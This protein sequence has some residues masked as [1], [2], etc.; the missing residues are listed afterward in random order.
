MS[1]RFTL[2]ASVAAVVSAFALGWWSRA[3]EIEDERAARARLGTE[4][5]RV[6]GEHTESRSPSREPG[7]ERVAPEAP[8][9]AAS[10]DA[11]SATTPEPAVVV[12]ASLSPPDPTLVRGVDWD[13][14]GE[15]V[16]ARS[17]FLLG[18]GAA[19]NAGGRPTHEQRQAWHELLLAINE[20]AHAVRSQAPFPMI[21][22][23]AG[24]HVLRAIPGR[25]LGLDEG[26]T[27]ELEGAARALLA[28][29][30]AAGP[31]T[32]PLEALVVRRTL[33]D[34]IDALLATSLNETQREKFRHA[35]GLWHALA[36]GSHRRRTYGLRLEDTIER[37]ASDWAAHYG[38]E[39]ARRDDL[40]PHAERLVDAASAIVTEHGLAG[41]ALDDADPATFRTV[42]RAFLQAQL[43]AESVFTPA[44]SDQ[45]LR[46]SQSRPALLFWFEDTA[47][48]LY[49]NA[50]NTGF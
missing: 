16:A 18:L 20:A 11:E 5:A 7:R 36:A 43:D 41:V 25:L 14:F 30:P 9:A 28:N 10:V 21:D 1:G 33:F 2:V 38:I 13:A 37:V 49:R 29:R 27:A 48:Q 19:V 22:P 50:E 47:S 3:V 4:L 17:E 31:R 40:L 8:T 26:Q 32:T 12:A 6:R 15:E 23:Q 24:P 45:Q 34:E 46:G 39:A 35:G 42:T 44:L